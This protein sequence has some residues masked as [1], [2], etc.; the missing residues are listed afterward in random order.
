MGCFIRYCLGIFFC[1]LQLSES[2]CSWLTPCVMI[3]TITSNQPDWGL[4]PTW[5]VSCCQI[6]SLFYIAFLRLWDSWH[7]ELGGLL[8]AKSDDAEPPTST[9]LSSLALPVRMLLPRIWLQTRTL[10]IKELHNTHFHISIRITHLFSIFHSDSTPSSAVFRFDLWSWY[11]WNF[12][13][14][15]EYDNILRS[16]RISQGSRTSWIGA[17]S[18]QQWIHMWVLSRNNLDNGSAEYCVVWRYF[19]LLK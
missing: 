6:F 14:N 8:H 13:H 12:V 10:E 17:I 1:L 3:Q 15:D 5:W 2:A 4:M 16:S 18:R 19:P 11:H 7:A 9:W